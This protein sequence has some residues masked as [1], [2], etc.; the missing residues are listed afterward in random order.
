MLRGIWDVNLSWVALGKLEC[1]TLL[2]SESVA[3]ISISIRCAHISPTSE[4]PRDTSLW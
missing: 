3:L 1:G 4:K 2:Q